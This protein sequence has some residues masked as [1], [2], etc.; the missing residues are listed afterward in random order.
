MMVE[1]RPREMRLKAVNVDSL[2]T[3]LRSPPPIQYR[4]F[5]TGVRSRATISDPPRPSLSLCYDKEN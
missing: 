4:K 5:V 3:L 2:I 1:R